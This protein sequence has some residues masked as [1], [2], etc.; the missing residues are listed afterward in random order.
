MNRTA[1]VKAGTVLDSG[2]REF[3]SNSDLN[4]ETQKVKLIRAR[5]KSATE[6]RLRSIQRKRELSRSCRDM[7]ESSTGNRARGAQA[8]AEEEAK[9]T[10]HR[11]R[12]QS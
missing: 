10:C 11:V 4:G 1:H 12:S 5:Q 9:M 7:S 6:S 8:K 3:W 2:K